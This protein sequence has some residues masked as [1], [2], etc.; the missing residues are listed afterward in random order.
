M[1]QITTYTSKIKNYLSNN[2]Y[3]FITL[4]IIYTLI[5]LPYLGWDFINDDL[6]NWQQRANIFGNALWTLNFADTATTYH[7]GVTLQYILF[8]ANKFLGLY[9]D[10]FGKG[11]PYQ[12]FLTVL[13]YQKLFV[14]ITTSALIAYLTVL[15]KNISGIKFALLT[16]VLL[17]LE[18]LFLGL[19]RAIHTDTL[20][21]AFISISIAEFYLMI[22][23]DR[24]HTTNNKLWSIDLFKLVKLGFWTSLAILTK[25][26]AIYLLLFY[27]FIYLCQLFFKAASLQ[28]IIKHYF[29]IIFSTIICTVIFWPALFVQPFN[30][31]DLVVNEGIG[32]VSLT[33]GHEQIW[34]GQETFNPG[35]WFYPLSM[36]FRYNTY[37]F[38]PFIILVCTFIYKKIKNKSIS[39][40]INLYYILFFITYL[41]MLT[42]VSKKL[43]RYSLPLLVPMI[44]II[45]QYMKDKFYD[46][47]YRF[48]ITLILFFSLLM[49]IL[50]LPNYLA[51]YSLSSAGFD[52][53]RN[54]ISDSWPSLYPTVADYVHTNYEI[55][56]LVL[57]TASEGALKRFA[58]F[59]V[60]NIT[61]NQNQKRAELFL[62]RS[63]E[64]DKNNSYISSN[65]LKFVHSFKI[66]GYDIYDL[67][68]K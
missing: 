22:N 46:N 45:S 61:N 58:K 34:F 52:K 50:I 57:A 28:Q 21:T 42:V 2:W 54:I 5:R 43:T 41:A 49:N 60:V 59:E 26:N 63:N 9:F 30:T 37:L 24:N 64:T 44:I 16:F 4:L 39:I 12:E 27:G 55:D 67:Y 14:V 15:F 53:S 68:T 47:R 56:N 7:P 1:D 25:T 20:L 29:S 6:A 65:N 48:I 40:D 31:I 23:N 32:T 33:E 10:I 66:I 13:Y 3:L 38:I 8:F 35:L 62:L 17:N 36:L 11:T 19:S 51:F 18:P